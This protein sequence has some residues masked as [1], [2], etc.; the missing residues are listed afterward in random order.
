MY[1]GPA[2]EHVKAVLQLCTAC[3]KDAGLLSRQIHRLFDYQCSCF[4]FHRTYIASNCSVQAGATCLSALTRKPHVHSDTD[5]VAKHIMLITPTI[6][7]LVIAVQ[8]TV[9]NLNQGLVHS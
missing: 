5:M 2:P 4:A 3:R 9:Q 8:S 6:A 7:L 1:A